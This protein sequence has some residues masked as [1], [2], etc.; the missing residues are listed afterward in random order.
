[1]EKTKLQYGILNIFL[2]NKD[3]LFIYLIIFHVKKLFQ[4]P[5]LIIGIFFYYTIKITYR[6]KSEKKK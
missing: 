6:E 3:N 2:R 1:M 4:T 5:L